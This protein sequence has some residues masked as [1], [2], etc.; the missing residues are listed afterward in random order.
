MP[1]LHL[2]EKTLALR[3]YHLAFLICITLNVKIE[4]NADKF[5]DGSNS[6]FYIENAYNI[7]SIEVSLS[8]IKKN[9][10]GLNMII[11]IIHCI[12]FNKIVCKITIST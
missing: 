7:V 1:D 10:Y 8:F 3:L 4:M 2:F 9:H 6:C 11:S 5:H 12:S